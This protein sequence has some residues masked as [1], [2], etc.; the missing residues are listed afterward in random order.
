MPDSAEQWQHRKQALT[1]RVLVSNG[2]W[3]MPP[4]TPLNPVI[5]GRVS[6]DGF[7]V[8]KVYFES[9]P[10]HYV[11]GLLF[12][13][14]QGSGPHPGV[15]CPH[16]HGGRLQDHG[17]KKIRE[18]I[19]QGA[20]R[21][22]GSGRFPKLARC[23][24]LARMGCVTF[25]FDMLGYAD[26]VQIPR[27]IAHGFRTR[28]P[29]FETQENWGFY[30]P[31]AESHLQSI[32]GLHTYNALRAL[33]F[34][35]SLPDVDAARIGVTGG[36]G[37]GTQTILLG[38]IDPRPAVAFPNGMVSTDMQG[39]C[40]CEN[41]SLLRIGTGNV[42]LAA[43]FAPRPQGMTAADDWTR[44]MMTK[45]FPELRKLYT[46][47]GVPKQVVCHPLTHFPHNYNYVSRAVMY[48]WFN[49]HLGL[50]LE[51]PIVEEDWRPLTEDEHSVWNEAHPRPKHDPD[52][53]RAVLRYLT[54]VSD[55]QIAS[56]KPTTAQ[57]MSGYRDI[58]GKAFE[59]VIGR[60]LDA[61]GKVEREHQ[62]TE[63][64]GKIRCSWDLL[65]AVHHG[66]EI[67]VVA[68]Y[69]KE[70][71]WNHQ[72]VLWIHGQGKQGLITH[73]GEIIPAIRK[74]LEAGFAV[75]GCD[76]LYQDEFLT[77]GESLRETR[78]VANEREYAGYTLGYNH[79]LFAQ[80]V[81]DIFTLIAYLQ[82]DVACDIHLV[83]THGAGPWVAAARALASD[84]VELAATDTQ[85]FRFADLSSFK[86]VNFLPGAVKYGDLPALLALNA[87]NA[88]WIAGES[89][90]ALDL[91]KSAYA[92]TDKP[93]RLHIATAIN[94]DVSQQIA[95]WL[96]KN[97]FEA[98]AW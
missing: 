18:F 36:S 88:L 47:L 74:L 87:P 14:E 61:V 38:A 60:T 1:R 78:T 29:E 51:E 95:N 35:S 73:E 13:P 31:Q 79:S 77:E 62:R 16:G 68:L 81:H 63:D 15:L 91:V 66:E 58:V 50:G 94:E 30:S 48:T 45:G 71:N 40:T 37:G 96:L 33:D 83:G 55:R 23:G 39:G 90:Q 85:G 98:T 34:L 82:Q 67:P 42:E 54:E 6:R 17:P 2:L 65:R 92:A 97:S 93:D 72:T 20:E 84:Q 8:E 64:F 52:H 10:G 11:T 25:I 70:G 21:F 86:D 4:K 22:E 27:A 28:R 41:C 57:T 24:Q 80:R 7:T 49:K 46:M 59:T 3:P 26:S 53:E 19:V 32:M 75:A 89:E 12:R 56:L 43:L 44:E 5:H 76:L 9:L 69:P